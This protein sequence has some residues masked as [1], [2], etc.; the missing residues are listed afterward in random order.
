LSTDQIATIFE[1][2]DELAP[3]VRRLTKAD[4]A[5]FVGRGSSYAVAMEGAIKLK[6]VSYVHAEAYSRRNS[7][8][9]LWR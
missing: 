6:E 5:F 4:H 9:G 8:T 3:M 1:R 7:N 2:E